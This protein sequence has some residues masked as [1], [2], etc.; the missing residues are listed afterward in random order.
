MI[1]VF[2]SIDKDAEYIQ[3]MYN[4]FISD[5]VDDL[6][7]DLVFRREVN[8]SYTKAKKNCLVRDR[9][10]PLSADA[11]KTPKSDI[12]QRHVHRFNR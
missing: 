3:N 2:I 5:Y 9:P 12:V 4:A 10:P 6:M 8:Y 7:E 1:Q 11:E